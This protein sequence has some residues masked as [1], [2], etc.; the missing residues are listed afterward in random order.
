MA[1]VRMNETQRLRQ[2][3]WWCWGQAIDAV[4]GNT[5]WISIERVTSLNFNDAVH[6]KACITVK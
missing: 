4:G 5:Y 6:A 3:W 1:P 2:S